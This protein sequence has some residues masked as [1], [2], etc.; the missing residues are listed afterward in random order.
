MILL[1]QWSDRRFRRYEPF[2]PLVPSSLRHHLE[3]CIRSLSRCTADQ[4]AGQELWRLGTLSTEITKDPHFMFIVS[5][6]V[7]IRAKR[8]RRRQTQ[9]GQRTAT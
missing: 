3:Q 7:V 4:G 9:R 2:V 6:L 1:P 5:L 8:R